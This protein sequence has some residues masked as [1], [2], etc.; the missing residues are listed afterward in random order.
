MKLSR[1]LVTTIE[2][3][4]S[5][6][7]LNLS[8]LWA[9]RELVLLFVRRDFV[10]QYAQTVLGPLWILLPPILTALA[11]TAVFGGIARIPTGGTSP[12]LFYLS[13]TVCWTLFSNSLT[14]VSATFVTNA[15][16]FGKVYFPRLAVPISSTLSNLVKFGIQLAILLAFVLLILARGEPVKPHAVAI[17]AIP[18]VA[19]QICVIGLGAG[20][21]IAAMTARYRDLHALMTFG[22][23]LWMYATPVVY[24]F[25]EVPDRFKLLVAF[26]PLV[27]PLELF[28]WAMLGA[29][30]PDS[31]YLLI[32]LATT[33]PIVC[34]GAL[35]FTRTERTFVDTV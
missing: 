35:L 1:K 20:L 27:A 13:G 10:A 19:A 18:L 8:E 3:P 33:A 31:L 4:G 7:S 34:L 15:A 30:L 5:G 14:Q 24:P 29:S 16:L 28:R 21:V 25:S 32:S 12:F 9:Y 2:P 6:L 11:F 22:T 23:Q 26:N 17:V